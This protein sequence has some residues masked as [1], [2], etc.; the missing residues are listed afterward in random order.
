MWLYLIPLMLGYGCGELGHYLLAV[1]SRPM[2]QDVGFG[3]KG[4]LAKNQSL[5]EDYQKQCTSISNES[6]CINASNS[7]TCSW[8]YT[9]QGIE[10]QIL[11][12]PT[13]VVIFTVVG[14]IFGILGDRYN[15]VRM[16]AISVVFFSVMTL[17]TGF[18]HQYWQLLTLRFL[19]G[20]GESACTPLASSLV[21]DWFP[22]RSRGRGMSIYNWGI[23]LG[24]GLAFAVGNYMTDADI[25][26][27]GWR[28]GYVVTGIAGF[29]MAVVI[30]IAIQEPPRGTIEFQTSISYKEGTNAEE[31]K[32]G[33]FREVAA[34]TCKNATVPLLLIGAC[35]RHSASFCWSYNAQLYFDD[36][37]PGTEVGFF[38]SITSIAG[39]TIGIVVGGLASDIL[40]RKYGV[41]TR[42][43][44]LVV[45][46]ALAA[47]CAAGVLLVE[48]P[49]CFIS[50]LVAYLFAEMW[51]G[52]LFTILVEFYPA[53]ARASAVACFIFVINNIGGNAQLI[54]PPLADLMG[55]RESLYLVYPGFYL[56]SSIFF[57]F[58]QLSLLVKTNT[59]KV[60]PCEVTKL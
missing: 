57:L 51:F 46:Q 10:Y 16:Y 8:D 31:K 27:S 25:L 45:S 38:M 43:W 56:T 30:I 34:L 3:D 60:D 23:Y 22:A 12:G 48:P 6:R 7:E 52:V 41:K 32:K 29:V 24:Y 21:A 26:D 1:T 37:Y 19:F 55:F 17:A 49:E 42:L 54:V 18:S 35:F 47:P 50:L 59:S 36:Y 40:A 33:K 39:G 15:R 11:A 13:Y 53:H 28:S 4:C 2:A 14:V 20:A 9:G 44:V 5:E 58:A